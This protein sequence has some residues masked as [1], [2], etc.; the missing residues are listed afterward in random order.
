MYVNIF[1]RLLVGRPWEVALKNDVLPKLPIT[2]RAALAIL[3]SDGVMLLLRL[4]E[5]RCVVVLVTLSA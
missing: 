3:S 4:D 2:F 1:K 5:N